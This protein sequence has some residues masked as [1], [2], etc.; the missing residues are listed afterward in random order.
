M[1]DTNEPD[2]GMFDSTQQLLR[3]AATVARN[4]LELLLVEVEEERARLLD[5]LVVAASAVACALMALIMI[6]VTVVIVFWD[7]HRVAVSIALSLAYLLAAAIG[8]WRLNIRLKNWR[9]FSATL[10]EFKKDFAWL[11]A[12]RESSSDSENRP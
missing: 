1:R 5:V 6:S 11:D 4:R 8:F 2:R 3:T 7:E 10:A 12:Q 9:A